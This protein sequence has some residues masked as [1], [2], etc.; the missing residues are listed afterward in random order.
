MP[1]IRSISGLRAT[2][3]NSLS[4]EIVSLYAKAFEQYLPKGE[5]IIG[6]D[7]RPSGKWIEQLIAETLKERGRTVHLLGIVP[8]PTV[9][10]LVEHTANAVGGISIT[11]SHNTSEWNGMKFMGGD[12]VFLDAAENQEFWKFADG[13]SSLEKSTQKGEIIHRADAIEQHIKTLLNISLFSDEMLDAIRSRKY[14][15]VVDAVNAGGSVAVPQLLEILGCEVV[16]LYCDG[17]GEFPHTPEPLAQNLTALADT[18]RLHNADIGIA[19]DP[20]ADRLVLVNEKGE[21]ISEEKTIV[22]AAQAVLESMDVLK[23]YSRNI[24]INL[25]TSRMIEDIA[26]EYGVTVNRTPVGEVNVVRNLQKNNGIFGGEGSG[27]VILPVCHYGRDSLVGIALLLKLMAS[28]HRKLSKLEDLLPHYEMLKTKINFSGDFEKFS[29]KLQESFKEST[30]TLGDG[31]RF[32]I[33]KSWVHIRSSNTEP[34]VRIIA[35][36]ATV[37]EAQELIDRAKDVLLN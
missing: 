33:A 11:A 18:V 9:Q 5:I 35:E 19:V 28:G 26:S 1:F 7:G 15:V 37:K 10:L 12:G 8:T 31:V 16:R 34:I 4:P 32:D 29:A 24:A 21:N 2:L 30:V 23:E 6:R 22:L 3:D 14:K 20:D 13:V 17:S 25:S 36:A 27:G